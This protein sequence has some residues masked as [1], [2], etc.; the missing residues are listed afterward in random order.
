VAVT[1]AVT[2][3]LLWLN[4][5][6]APAPRLAPTTAPTTAPTPDPTPDPAPPLPVACVP[7]DVVVKA[8]AAAA[9]AVL[10]RGVGR[11][12]RALGPAGCRVLDCA[13]GWPGA[14]LAALR[15][16]GGNSAL[17]LDVAGLADAEAAA[18]VHAAAAPHV[19]SLRVL[20]R[21][22]GPL[23]GSALTPVYPAVDGAAAP[24][25]DVA[26]PRGSLAALSPWDVVVVDAVDAGTGCVAPGLL[27][28]V[29]EACRGV[30]GWGGCRW[31]LCFPSTTTIVRG[32]GVGTVTRSFRC[33]RAA[34][35]ATI[36]ECFPPAF[37]G[38]SAQRCVSLRR[39]DMSWLLPPPPPPPLRDLASLGAVQRSR[40]LRA[41]VVPCAMEV[42]VRAVECVTLA[43]F[44]T[45]SRAL[46]GYDLS[47]LQEYAVPGFQV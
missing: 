27:R 30:R 23:G 13:S 18:A 38:C 29:T 42:M 22:P 33:V 12:V 14:G 2:E 8:N 5:A 32:S 35:G 6:P 39:H 7:E 20:R 45:V 21:G 1:A 40:G 17:R 16:A 47:P 24:G 28:W 31:A 43:Q 3:D 44:G 46:T 36:D 10:A 19:A 26:L 11:A 4:A 25:G 9:V 34:D 37:C 41:M 15:A